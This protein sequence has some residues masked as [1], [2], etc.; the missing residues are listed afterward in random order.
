M[1]NIPIKDYLRE[2]RIFSARLSV[3][4]GLVVVIMLVLLGRM[5]YLQV[6]H[7]KHYVT[8][9]RANQIKPLPVPPVRGLILDRNGIVLAQ[10]YPAYTLEVTPEH[11]DDMD[12]TLKQLSSLVKI[13]RRDLSRFNK[14]RRLR[15]GFETQILRSN[16]SDEE[17]ARIAINRPHLQ[18]VELRARLQRHYPLGSLGVHVIGYVGRINAAENKRIDRT[19]YRGTQHI[20]KLGIEQQ[21]ED[22][23]LGKVGVEHVETNARGRALHVVT[24]ETP[25]AGNDIFLNIDARMQ[26]AAEKM[27]A[28]KRGAV[29]AIDPTSG[30]ILTMASMPTYDPNLFVNGIDHVSYNA[31][32]A[33]L[34]KP[35]INRALNG[36]YPPG[37]TIKPFLALAALAS[38]KT[39]A[40]KTTTCR[41]L[42][43]LPGEARP[44]RDWK[45]NGHGKVD[46]HKAIVESCDVYFYKNAVMLGIDFIH[47]YLTRLG[48]GRLTGIDLKGESSGLV[49]SRAW[50]TARGEKW[51][52]GETVVTG[53]G[54][55]PILVTPLQLASTVASLANGGRLM[56]PRIM[57]ATENPVSKERFYSQFSY[58]QTIT[59]DQSAQLETIIKAMTDV[60][61]GRKGTARRIGWN[62]PY[63]IAGKTG[64]AQVF[65]IKK[66]EKYDAKLI[67]ERLRDHALFISFAPVE[68][69]RIAIAVIVENG[70]HGSSAAAPIARK[71]M[72]YYLLPDK[73]PS[74]KMTNSQETKTH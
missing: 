19:N 43:R 72:D 59:T 39:D 52:L 3:L 32:L 54:Q 68:N 56:R 69:P 51:Y 35:L 48:F 63:R 17:A 5:L 65:S 33:D 47:K 24:R 73:M 11:V 57:Y 25:Q 31:L 50:R 8:R 38:G 15:P 61:H 7:H 14:L 67:P 6:V 62:A 70:G 60:V 40:S 1:L 23:L 10:N 71:L 58:D 53:I 36:Q 41:G 46:M 34:D 2:S 74:L 12:A 13:T 30:A 44:Y 64:T 20:G 42:F 16:L 49:P 22:V 4:A 27:L 45:R 18:G 55:G 9:A 29:V 28:G 37:S 66:G 21:Y 26:A